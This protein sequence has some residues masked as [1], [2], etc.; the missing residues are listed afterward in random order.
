MSSQ[1]AGN[2]NFELGTGDLNDVLYINVV[3]DV[4]CTKEICNKTVSCAG[5][6]W[7]VG[8]PGNRPIGARKVAHE[9]ETCL[10]PYATRTTVHPHPMGHNT[11]DEDQ[12]SSRRP[13]VEDYDNTSQHTSSTSRMCIAADD[14]ASPTT[15]VLHLHRPPYF[16]RGVD[17]DVHVWVSIVSRW[18]YYSGRA[19][20]AVDICCVTTERS[21]L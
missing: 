15:E 14:Q 8:R 11:H 6:E 5:P 12:A 17:D 3:I 4:D 19:L 2:L 18:L 10:G 20:N 21:R 9:L 16:S 7:L 13:R 1:S